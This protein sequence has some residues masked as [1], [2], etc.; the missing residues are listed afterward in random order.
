M[1]IASK[2]E[3]LVLNFAYLK[4]LL[5]DYYRIF[6]KPGILI[7]FRQFQLDNYRLIFRILLFIYYSLICVQ[8]H[9]FQHKR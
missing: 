6:Y 3:N 1:I 2:G 7:Q 4:Y 8:L 5:C 9:N